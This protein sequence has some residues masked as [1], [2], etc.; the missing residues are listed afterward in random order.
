MS[1]VGAIYPNTPDTFD[2]AALAIGCEVIIRAPGDVNV[3]G[4]VAEVDAE[5]QSVKFADGRVYVFPPEEE[6]P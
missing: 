5:A 4:I 3:I 1:D 2:P 6:Q